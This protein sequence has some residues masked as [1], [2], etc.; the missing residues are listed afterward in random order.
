MS[1]DPKI[2]HRRSIRLKGYDYSQEGAYFITICTKDREY[3]FGE[4]IDGK[5]DVNSTG[6][7]VRKIWTGIPG[8][9]PGFLIDYYVVMPNHFHGIIKIQNKFIKSG[10]GVGLPNPDIS[11]NEIGKNQG[12]D[13][14][15]ETPPLQ[16]NNIIKNNCIF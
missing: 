9:Y 16:T 5:M 10:V 12:N 7:M 4:I 3:M 14:G 13:K 2:H 6:K 11:I 15:G 1:F 8:H